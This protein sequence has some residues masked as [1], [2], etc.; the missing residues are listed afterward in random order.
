MTI[1]LKAAMRHVW[2]KE[3][4]IILWADPVCIN[5]DGLIERSE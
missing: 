1:N 2:A 3:E 4:T 5:Q